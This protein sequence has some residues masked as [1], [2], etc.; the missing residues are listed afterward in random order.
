MKNED[1]TERLAFRMAPRDLEMLQELSAA[2]GESVSTVLRQ[3]IRRGHAE[4][5]GERRP[6][7]TR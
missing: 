2:E 4:K 1:K 6:R 5:F 3:L 7:A